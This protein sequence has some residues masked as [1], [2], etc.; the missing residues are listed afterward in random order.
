M[1]RD[2][3]TRG[4]RSRSIRGP[5]LARSNARIQFLRS[6]NHFEC[7]RLPSSFLFLPF[8]FIF[9]LYRS[10]P[11]LSLALRY[12][13]EQSTIF[14]L[15]SHLSSP[16]RVLSFL[17][18]PLRSLFFLSVRL[19]SP[20][21]WVRPGSR[22]SLTLPKNKFKESSCSRGVFTLASHAEFRIF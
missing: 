1:E 22:S 21:P 7:A 10:I 6:F 8:A 4:K 15:P 11:G 17:F 16:F 2:G 9:R 12:L 5:E 3:G 13:R 14:S 18:S 19:L 20:P